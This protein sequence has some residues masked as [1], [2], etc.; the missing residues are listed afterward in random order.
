MPRTRRCT[1]RAERLRYIAATDDH[2]I[3]VAAVPRLNLSR[4]IVDACTFECLEPLNWQSS[5][6]DT[7][8]HHECAGADDHAVGKLNIE[9]PFA[10]MIVGGDAHSAPRHGEAGA[11]LHGLHFAAS[12]EVTAGN[13]GGKAHLVFDPRRGA[14]LPADGAIFQH[15]SRH[16]FRTGINARGGT[17]RPCTN[18][19]HIAN[20]MI[21]QHQ[22]EPEK[23]GDLLRRGVIDGLLVAVEHSGLRGVMEH[24][25]ETSSASPEPISNER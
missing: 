3:R 5:V 4:G 19:Q 6:L 24:S 16:A 9:P 12:D 8:G 2:G 14:G 20:L 10:V 15:Q 18:D 22:I 11:E 17:G 21:L 25:A 7:C 13:A 1:W 23:L